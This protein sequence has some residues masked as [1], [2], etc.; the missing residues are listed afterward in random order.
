MIMEI[1]NVGKPNHKPS[2]SL[3]FTTVYPMWD[4][5]M[6]GSWNHEKLRHWVPTAMYIMY[7]WKNISNLSENPKKCKNQLSMF[8]GNISNLLLKSNM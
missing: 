7:Y 5:Q 2:P 3:R 1:S 6:V 8:I 4:T